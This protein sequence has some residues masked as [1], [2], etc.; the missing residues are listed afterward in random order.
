MSLAR[1]ARPT[2]RSFGLRAC[3]SDVIPIVHVARVIRFHVKDEAAAIK[4]DE[5]LRQADDKLKASK[6]QGFVKMTRTVCKGEWAYEATTIFEGLENFKAYAS[7]EFRTEEMLPILDEIKKL[8]KKPED[9][10]SGNRVY[11]EL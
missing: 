1:L 2:T 5:L 9:F 10:Y 8:A 6:P 4:A 11:D 7:G 3:S